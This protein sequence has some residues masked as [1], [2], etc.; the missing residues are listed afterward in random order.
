MKRE[1]YL[2]RKSKSC[3]AYKLMRSGGRRSL[4]DDDR[5]RNSVL[6]FLF[7]LL[8]LR[9]DFDDFDAFGFLIAAS[10]VRTVATDTAVVLRNECVDASLH[11][12]Q[13]SAD[14]TVLLLHNL[15][16]SAHLLLTRCAKQ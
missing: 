7:D 15:G 6:Y 16:R 8:L 14:A 1:I 2:C 4:G 5:N 11:S 12:L 9:T 10:C 13:S 3:I